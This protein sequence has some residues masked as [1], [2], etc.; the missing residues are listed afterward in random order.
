MVIV[1]GGIY[2]I[3]PD[4]KEEIDMDKIATEKETKKRKKIYIII[5][6]VCT[7]VLLVILGIMLKDYIR[8]Q[9]NQEYYEKLAEEN[10][11]E[12]ETEVIGADTKKQES[13]L[14]TLLGIKI[15]EKNIH[16]EELYK[17]NEDIYA[18][19]YIP[20]TS[21]DYPIVQHPTDN[22]YYINHNLDGSEGKPATIMTQNY[23]KK[24]FS[25]SNT[26]IY[27]HNMRNG[28][29]FRDLHNFEKEEFFHENKYVYVYTPDRVNVYQ[30][31]AAYTFTNELIPVDYDLSTEEGFQEYLDEVFSYKGENGFF[32]E[33]MNITTENHLITLSTCTTP[34]DYDYRYL[35]QGVLVNDPTLAEDEIIRTI[36]S[37][38]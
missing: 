19:V 26:V 7:I 10:A 38:Q 24:D 9:K 17:E 37:I 1:S 2:W 20:G 23:N 22:Q 16:W 14:L 27:G 8:E 21:I 13:E 4:L 36:Q 18:W 12:I 5:T 15:P 31:F 28:S 34:T 29:M 25:D 35:V 32:R 33:N 30:V 3:L 11:K 6:F